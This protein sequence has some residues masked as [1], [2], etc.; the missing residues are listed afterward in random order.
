METTSQPT[1]P[2]AD[3]TVRAVT[4]PLLLITLG[5]LFLL[6]YSGGPQVR[7]TWPVLLI[8]WGGAWALTH[9]VGR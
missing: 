4:I 8:I 2:G 5:S 1:S 7:Q 3:E 9:V 6:D